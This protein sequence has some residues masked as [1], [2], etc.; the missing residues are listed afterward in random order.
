VPQVQLSIANSP[1]R[2]FCFKCV[3]V[4]R[5][6]AWK[7]REGER[8]RERERVST[9]SFHLFSVVLRRVDLKMKKLD[10]TKSLLI[11]SEQLLRIEDHD[12]A[13]RPGFGG[14]NTNIIPLLTFFTP[15]RFRM[16]WKCHPR[17]STVSSSCT[18]WT[19]FFS[20]YGCEKSHFELFFC[21]SE[22][23]CALFEN[24]FR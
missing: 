24:V 22:W 20:I 4:P 11:K 17:W 2:Q 8:K 12:F 15:R 16:V 23:R 9:L 7:H 1:D 21:T 5:R 6:E 14:K 18:C 10:S 13:M 3:C 19:F